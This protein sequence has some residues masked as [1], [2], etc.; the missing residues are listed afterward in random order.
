MATAWNIIHGMIGS[1][2][3]A[4]P[5]TAIARLGALA[6]FLEKHGLSVAPSDVTF[7]P[8]LE[9]IVGLLALAWLAPNTQRVLAAYEPVLG[10]DAATAVELPLEPV[11]RLGA[12][13]SSNR[14]GGRD[15][16]SRYQ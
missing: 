16:C 14:R 4:L 15:S 13:D 11:L 2:G 8:M 6:G 7:F 9:W 3:I 1:H 12:G 10:F 5:P